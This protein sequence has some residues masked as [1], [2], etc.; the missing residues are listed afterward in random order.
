MLISFVAVPI[1]A[2][3]WYWTEPVSVPVINTIHNETFPYLSNDGELLLWNAQG[4]ICM[5]RWDGECWQARE[6]LPQPVNTEHPEDAVAITPDHQHIYWV[7]WRPGGYGNWD[8]WRCSWDEENNIY[9]EAECLGDNVNST[10][11]EWGICFTPDGTRMFFVTDI[12]IKNGQQGYGYFDIWYCDWDSTLGDWG[13][14]YNAG[15]TINSIGEDVTPYISLSGTYINYTLYFSSN[16]HHYL[17]TWFGGSDLFSIRWN[18]QNWG[19]LENMGSPLNSEFVD[20]S[21]CI[22]PDGHTIYYANPDNRDDP[23]NYDIV[24]SK[25]EP[26]S[27]TED[28]SFSG[29][30]SINIQIYPNPSNSSCYIIIDPG[31]INKSIN[32]GIYD[33]LG[34]EVKYL[35]EYSIND[36]VSIRWD[37]TDS[38]QNR[39]ASGV[40]FVK[41]FTEGELTQIEK[42]SFIK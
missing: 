21:P 41:V 27:V 23:D 24:V 31:I 2:Q 30:D 26:N 39:V 36:T 8:I 15:A 1:A 17:P 42:F 13:L 40:Y 34:K 33:L 5:S 9:G 28:S 25:L 6:I 35:G 29:S 22:A 19:E 38:N 11:Y 20:E 14:P 12:I 4:T 18:G 37:G 3:E 7:S 10:G 32:I 16:H